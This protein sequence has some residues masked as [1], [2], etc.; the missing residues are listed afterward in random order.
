MRGRP[1]RCSRLAATL[2]GVLFMFSLVQP[3][4]MPGMTMSGSSAGMRTDGPDA[5][6]AVVRTHVL[7][8]AAAIGT[9]GPDTVHPGLRMAGMDHGRMAASDADAGGAPTTP[10]TPDCTQHDCCCSAGSAAV[11]APHAALSW[12]PEH[13]I[14]QDTPRRGNCVAH[15]DRQVRLP[16][17][18]G[19][20]RSIRA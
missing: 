20:P 7:D 3:G 15:M 16:F 12:L 19:P 13:V 11:I 9:S 8:S 1:S 5:G 18:N 2:L 10:D 17:A 14:E 6:A 4:G